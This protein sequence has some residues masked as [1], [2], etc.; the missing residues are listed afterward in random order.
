MKRELAGYGL[1]GLAQLALD[2]ACF[3]LLTA[4]GCPV[5]P[6]NLAGRVAGAC[7]GFWGNGRF[8]FAADGAAPRLGP[9]RFGRYVVVWLVM[10]ALG[11]LAVAGLDHLR[12]LHASWLG[13][14]VVDGTLAV[15]GFLASKHW[16][17]R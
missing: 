8:T 14:P 11:T 4:A 5:V 3:V 6:A 7:L 2:W 12:G 10:A 13:K 16:I 9:R 1:V 15:L 17:Y